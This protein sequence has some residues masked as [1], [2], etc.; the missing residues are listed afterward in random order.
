MDVSDEELNKLLKVEI[1]EAGLIKR[2]DIQAGTL[3]NQLGWLAIRLMD[4][5]HSDGKYFTFQDGS[6]LEAPK[7]INK[8]TYAIEQALA[9]ISPDKTTWEQWISKGEGSFYAIYKKWFGDP[10]AEPL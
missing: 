1:E 6:R 5:F 4:A 3:Y 2:D 7:E 9:E 10:I 8:E